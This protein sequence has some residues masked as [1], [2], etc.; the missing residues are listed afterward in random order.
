MQYSKAIHFHDGEVKTITDQECLKIQQELLN[1][2]E[3]L[4]VQGELINTKS[5]KRVGSHHATAMMN[6]IEKKQET[7]NLKLETPEDIKKY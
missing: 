6:N 2:A 7:T 1:G 5:I 4:Q 3:W